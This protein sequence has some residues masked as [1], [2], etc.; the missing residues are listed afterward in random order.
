MQ[1]VSPWAGPPFM[2]VC[3]LIQNSD[4]YTEDMQ[5]LCGTIA[6]LHVTIKRHEERT[7]AY[8]LCLHLRS[9]LFCLLRLLEGNSCLLQRVG[10]KHRSVALDG[11]HSTSGDGASGS[12]D[13]AM[14]EKDV[15]GTSGSGHTVKEGIGYDGPFLQLGLHFEHVGIFGL[16]HHLLVRCVVASRKVL[17]PR[18]RSHGDVID[19]DHRTIVNIP[20]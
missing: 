16:K 3:S 8:L 14:G 15:A 12:H 18:R 11:I 9:L 7:F 1:K 19:P 4:G 17:T 13:R 20:G 5:V 2:D 10:S 6:E